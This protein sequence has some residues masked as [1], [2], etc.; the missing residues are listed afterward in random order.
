[1]TRA[2]KS[3]S[4]QRVLL[5]V[6]N[7]VSVR[8][9]LAELCREVAHRFE[10]HCACALDTL[11]TSV[12]P[13]DAD[14][15]FH[16]MPFP[17]GM[18]AIGH[19]RSGILLNDL[20]RELQPKLIHAHFSSAILTTALAHRRGWPRTI[21]TFQG[22]SFPLAPNRAKARLL[23]GAEAWA[24]GRLDSVWVLSEDDRAALQEAAPHAIVLQQPGYGFGCD[25]GR[26]DSNRSVE[27]ERKALMAELG[28]SEEHKVFSFVGRYVEF[29]GFALLVRAFL[30][31]AQ[32]NPGA[33]LLLIGARDPLHPTGLSQAEEAAWRRSSQI[34]DVGWTPEVERYLALSYVVVF[35]S[36]REGMPVSLM[37]SLAMGVPVI[38]RDSRGCR[39]V[40]RDQE[41]GFVLKECTVES[42]AA[43]MQRVLDSPDLHKHMRERALGGRER[44]SRKDYV[45]AQIGIYDSVLGV[46]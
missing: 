10:V 36:Q 6:P 23:K 11:W 41:D 45:A 28:L 25:L 7:I 16:D 46:E 27:V 17:R 38:T 13:V 24:A 20:V 15:Q 42:L 8:S 39:E 31:L 34:V 35:P 4:P 9:F 30:R 5:V 33:R 44:F 18:N 2:D 43:V 21:G 22:I 40:V 37:E 32:A 12:K 26:F 29:K 14:V 19:W 3:D 1:M